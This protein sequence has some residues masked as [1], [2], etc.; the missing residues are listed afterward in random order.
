MHERPAEFEAAGRTEG[1]VFIGRAQE[2]T[3]P[4]PHRETPH[5]RQARLPVDR[6]EHRDGQP[7]H[8]HCVDKD[9]TLAPL[10]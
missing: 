4:V 5:P 6:Q 8:F 2:K 3:T 7:P 10:C 1:V 9:L